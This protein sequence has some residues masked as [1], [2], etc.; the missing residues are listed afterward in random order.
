M[1]IAD[2]IVESWKKVMEKFVK[3]LLEGLRIVSKLRFL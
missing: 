1:R 2:S 3:S